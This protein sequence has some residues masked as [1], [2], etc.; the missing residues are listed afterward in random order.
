MK[1]QFVRNMNTKLEPKLVFE[2]ADPRAT[3]KVKSS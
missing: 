1:R 3:E 2:P